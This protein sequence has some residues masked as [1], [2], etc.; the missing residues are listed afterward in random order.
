MKKVYYLGIPGSFSYIAAQRYFGKFSNYIGVESF[1]VLFEQVV[2]DKSSLGII[3]IENTIAGSVYD[4]YDLLIKY[5][6]KIIG[7][8]YMKI[9][10]CLL[11]KKNTKIDL[12]TTVYSHYKALEQCKK[13][14]DRHKH[15][16]PSAFKDTAASAKLVSSSE[17]KD[18]AAI[19]STEVAEMNSLNI[20]ASNIED[21]EHNFT[22]FIV[23]TAKQAEPDADSN[24]AS[25]VFS[26]KHEPGS[27]V[28]SLK[29]IANHKV[30]VLQI[31]SRPI[32]TRPFEYLF[33][34][35]IIWQDQPIQNIQ[36]MLHHL[37]TVTESITVLGFY[38][39]KAHSLL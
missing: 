21:T 31:Q 32:P 22:R 2:S 37:S 28:R 20:L 26:L 9:E 30:N 7:E 36:N 33:Y 8:E 4:N 35:D 18:I 34:I 1:R 13:F 25:V 6:T 39:S 24:K 27:L 3:P 11:A 10:L 12:I 15:M 38:K 19:A 29:V 17:D 14:F 16:I 23:I 5:G